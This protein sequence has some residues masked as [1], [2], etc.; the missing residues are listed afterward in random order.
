MQRIKELDSIRGVAA[1]AI[2]VY[3]LWFPQVGAFGLAVD[4][5][6]VLSGYLI[7][8][9]LLNNALS[10]RFLLSFYWRRSLR[11]W[12]IY[13]LTLTVLVLTNPFLPTPG[14]LEDLPYYLTY[15]Q[16]IPHA[17]AGREPTFPLAFRHTWTL[18][19]EEQFYVFWPA[20]LWTVGRKRLAVLASTLIGLAVVTRAFNLNQ[21]ILIT[22][23]DGLALGGLLAGLVGDRGQAYTMPA[24]DRARFTRLALGLAGLVALAL[25]AERL[26]G[27]C[28]WG[29]IPTATSESLKKLGTNLVAFALVGIIVIHAGHPRL[30][31]LRD[32]RLV[33][34]GT[35]S[36]G[37]Y[38]YHHFLFKLWENL[39]TQFHWPENVAVD[40]IKLSAS[41]SLAAFSWHF[42]ER[43]ILGLKERFCYKTAA[44]FGGEVPGGVTELSSIKAG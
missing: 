16:E 9:I 18:A 35:I 29:L 41:I 3:H 7:T 20:L 15:T 22:R 39:A 27:A 14:N 34:L 23:C 26:F 13:Y 21:F 40:L 5:F 42:I 12:P 6:F 28:W 11:I 24:G 1:L 17:W 32:R 33:Y 25:V 38:L 44:S 31:C 37:I 30:R 2:V 43:P 19:I 10:E 36:Y 4:L 8:S